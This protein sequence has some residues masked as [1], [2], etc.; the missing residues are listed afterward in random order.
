MYGEPGIRNGLAGTT[1][2]FAEPPQPELAGEDRSPGEDDAERRA[3][4]AVSNAFGSTAL[5]SAPNTY[6]TAVSMMPAHGTPDPLILS[7]NA[8]ACFDMPRLRSTRPVEYSPEF[9]LDMAAT[10]RTAWITS[11][12][13]FRPMRPNT[14]TNGLVPAL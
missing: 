10:I 1:P 6:T 12:I 8:G 2:R 11:P 5:S 13:Q 14:E 4:S 7:V 3:S 9:R